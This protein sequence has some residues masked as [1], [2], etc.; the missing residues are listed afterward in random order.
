ML[1]NNH[2][3]RYNN[4]YSPKYSD[5]YDIYDK[6]RAHMT[7]LRKIAKPSAHVAQTDV[8][9]EQSAATNDNH[10]PTIEK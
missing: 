1:K 3:G 2:R 5:P 7:K 10:Q 9:P 4:D 6:A 8:V